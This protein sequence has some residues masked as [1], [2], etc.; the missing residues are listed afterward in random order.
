ME[1]RREE[2]I[3]DSVVRVFE[4]IDD[5]KLVGETFACNVIDFSRSGVRLESTHALVPDTQLNIT[6]GI[7]KPISR[8]QLRGEIL[9]TDI[10]ENVCYLGILLSE[11]GATDYESWATYIESHLVEGAENRLVY[12]DS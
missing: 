8:F 5:P 9:W 3:E 1:N 7:G 6:L 12:V 10:S 4:C 2:R 11:D